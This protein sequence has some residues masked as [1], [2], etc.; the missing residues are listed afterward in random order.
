MP[1]ASRRAGEPA[2]GDRPPLAPPAPSVFGL[3]IEYRPVT[4][5]VPYAR[6]A[7]THS[8]H[9]LAEIAAAMRQWGWTNPVL[10]DP[11]GGIIAGHGRILA[12]ER[13][14][15][16]GRS[17]ARVP[18]GQVPCL[19]IPGLSEADKAALVLADNRIALSAG[20]DDALLKA[21]LLLIEGSGLDPALTGFTTE[22]L[23]DLLSQPDAGGT[24]PDEAPAVEEVAVARLGD[25]WR[26]GEHVLV[27]GD[28]TDAGAVALCL[29]GDRP[30]LMVT[31]PP[32]GVKYD[33]AWRNGVER[34]NGTKVTARA[35]GKVL[36]DDIADWRHAWAL[37][38]GAVAYVWHAG[39]FSSE[40]AASLR[41]VRF[42][43]RAQIVWVKSRHTLGRG[44]YHPQHEPAFYAVREGEA[45]DGW[46]FQA[47]HEAATYAVREGR[48]ADYRGG[49]KQST[50]WHIDHRVSETGHGTQKPV[51]AMK[52]PIENNSR[53]G[54]LVYEPFSGSG[55]TIIACQMTG[56]KARA[57]ELHPPYVDVAI[58]RWEAFS[59]RKA[60]LEVQASGKVGKG[61]G[62]AEMA[63][64]RAQESVG[65]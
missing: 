9:Q 41:S 48:G 3:Q 20:W 36:N 38:P 25:R 62:F 59:G 34:A 53:P 24:D 16:A 31:D 22:E 26:L 35:T 30:H 56:R 6:N 54:D 46:R 65:G 13:E 44:D 32:Y 15:Q 11:D 42:Q 49:R 10:I 57:L 45:D 21:E 40:V 37:F 23:G 33:P 64:R 52:R 5:L 50:V 12:A 18:D 28:C 8:T 61:A 29:Q 1:R 7:R 55:T 19:V 60:V 14:W 51:E 58:K 63:A 2:G 27:C 17:I 4:V 43:I 47:D 39:L